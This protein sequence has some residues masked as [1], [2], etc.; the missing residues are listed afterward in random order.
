MLF[1]YLNIKVLPEVN[2]AYLGVSIL[3]S[4]FR[5]G[6]PR[7]S[8]HYPAQSKCLLLGAAEKFIDFTLAK[9]VSFVIALALNGDP[10]SAR[11]ASNEINSYV[12][13]I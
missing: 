11:P 8:C 13:A 2:L 12:L 4:L 6:A 7:A 9:P 1:P 3:D 10:F 5:I